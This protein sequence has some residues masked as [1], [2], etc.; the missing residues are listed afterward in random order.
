VAGVRDTVSFIAWISFGK[1][2]GFEDLQTKL[3]ANFA[4]KKAHNQ[5]HWLRS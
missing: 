2:S 4:W 1:Y 3:V 5:I